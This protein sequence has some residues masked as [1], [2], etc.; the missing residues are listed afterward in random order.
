MENKIIELIITIILCI[1]VAKCVFWFFG[2]ILKRID[3]SV[4]RDMQDLYTKEEYAIVKS[5]YYGL[6][7]AFLNNPHIK[8]IPIRINDNDNLEKI[9]KFYDTT[10]VHLYMVYIP[11]LDISV[12]TLCLEMHYPEYDSVMSC[13]EFIKHHNL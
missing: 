12:S 5:N 4:L 13:N 8:E 11:N 1:V 6:Y 3:K 7:D 9:A 10:N 2:F